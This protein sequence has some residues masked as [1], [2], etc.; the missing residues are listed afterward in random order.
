MKG[1][2]PTAQDVARL[3]GVS[4]ST[5]SMILNNKP[6]VSFLPETVER[7]QATA[8]QLNYKIK[9]PQDVPAA[10]GSLLIAVVTPSLA[11]PYY[12]TLVQSLENEASRNDCGVFVCNTYH[13]PATENHYLNLF[14]QSSLRGIIYTFMPYHWEKVKALSLSIPTVVVGDK[15]Q[16]IDID[17]VELNS[18]EAGELMARHLLNYKHKKIAFITTPLSENNLPRLR[19]LEGVRNAVH[20]SGA[21]LIIKESPKRLN[22]PKY[23][24][25]LEY[26]VGYEY[27]ASL[28]KDP[29]ITAYIGVN[30]MVAYGIIDA[31]EDKGIRIPE[32]CSVCGFDNVFPSRFRRVSLTTIDSLL[33]EKGRDAFNLLYQKVSKEEQELQTG[34]HRIEYKPVLVTRNSTGPCRLES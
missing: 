34:I 31:M 19:R 6:N 18:I 33:M 11:N 21:E 7:V 10:K 26:D 23:N 25:N 13:D 29:S 15:N 28:I 5:V 14:S 22:S 12:S 24:P 27:G 3:A 32:D 8:R 1:K 4:Q 30:D 9:K 16:S 20:S 17:T 2:K